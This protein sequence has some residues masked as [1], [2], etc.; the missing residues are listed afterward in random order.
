MLIYHLA[1]IPPFFVYRIKKKPCPSGK[2]TIYDLDE[3][4]ILSRT[5]KVANTNEILMEKINR[6]DESRNDSFIF[7]HNLLAS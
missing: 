6:A 5:Y 1:G 4:L 2:V 7:Q 3:F